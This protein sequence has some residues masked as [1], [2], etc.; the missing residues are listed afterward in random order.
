MAEEKVIKLE[1]IVELVDNFLKGEVTAEE[2]A[3]YGAKMS[4][5]AYLPLLD[6]MKIVIALSTRYVYSDTELHEVRIAELYRDLF[7]YGLLAPYGNI[8]CDNISLITFA[9]YD[10]LFPIFYPFLISYCKSDY[11]ILKEYL[12]DTLDSYATRDFVEAVNGISSESLSEATKENKKMLREL[13]NNKDLI[14]DLKEIAAMNNPIT[15]KVV[16]ELRNIAVEKSNNP[17]KED[18]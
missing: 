7:F 15:Q 18:K 11:E 8:N 17:E 12:H 2:M 6:K 9:N 16:E 14:K 3:D 13:G 5:R 1:D 10:K 4:V